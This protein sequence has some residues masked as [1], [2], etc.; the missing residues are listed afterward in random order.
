NR[1]L[2]CGGKNVKSVEKR[3]TV[4]FAEQMNT[5]KSVELGV[6]KKYSSSN[7]KSLTLLN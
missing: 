7:D 6:E 4:A 1:G 2:C 3:A 5:P